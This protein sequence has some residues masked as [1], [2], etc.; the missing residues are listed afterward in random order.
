MMVVKIGILLSMPTEHVQM[1]RFSII[2]INVPLKN[3]NNPEAIK[4]KWDKSDYI[5]VKK[6]SA[7]KKPCTHISKVIK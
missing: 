5:K 2:A 6:I 7:L 4:E 1:L 3:I